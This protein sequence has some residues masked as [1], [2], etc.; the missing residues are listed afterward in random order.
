MALPAGRLFLWHGAH[1][2]G[3]TRP[4]IR[5]YI[6]SNLVAAQLPEY[7]SGY[8]YTLLL[9]TTCSIQNK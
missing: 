6:A 2:L 8:V 3:V 1:G 9:L 7:V 4:K 5:K